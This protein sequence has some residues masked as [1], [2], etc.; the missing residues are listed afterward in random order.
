VVTIHRDRRLGVT[1]LAGYLGL[2]KP[3]MTGLVA[4]AE[5][6]GLL[7]R[8]GNPAD[9]RAVDVFITPGGAALAERV[10]GEGERALAPMTG[11]LTPREQRLQPTVAGD[12]VRPASSP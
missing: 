10:R 11:E 6:P 12:P 9:G 1:A 2:D 7:R 4:R 5:E 8:A 3:S